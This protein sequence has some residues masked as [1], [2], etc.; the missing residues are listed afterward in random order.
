MTS[1]IP[2]TL[3][4]SHVAVKFRRLLGGA[5]WTWSQRGHLRSVFHQSNHIATF[6]NI[7]MTSS[8]FLWKLFYRFNQASSQEN[9][10]K[11]HVLTHLHH[12]FPKIS[13]APRI[14]RSRR[15]PPLGRLVSVVSPSRSWRI[16][17]GIIEFEIHC[18]KIRGL[19]G[20]SFINCSYC[21]VRH[22]ISGFRVVV[23]LVHGR[24]L[25]GSP[26]LVQSPKTSRPLKTEEIIRFG[27]FHH[28]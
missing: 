15:T 12:F 11:T 2:R 4:V 20:Q 13:A 24:L 28:I 5:N 21:L 18:T 22:G 27:R 26:E 1:S 25:R 7:C 8:E 14:E 17:G 9:P 10:W 6:D 16:T 19:V 3:A 23:H